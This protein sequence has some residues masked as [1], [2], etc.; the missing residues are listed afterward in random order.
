LP[1]QL[2]LSTPAHDKSLW[3]SQKNIVR[4]TFACDVEAP[5][6]GD[7]LIQEL[8]DGGDFHEEDLSGSFSF[9]LE[10][11]GAGD[12][13]LRIF[14]TTPRLTHRKWYT[15]RNTGS[16]SG[17]APFELHYVVQVGDATNDG[18]VLGVDF[19]LVNAA[20]PCLSGCGDA[21]R[22]DI[23]GD[24]F[25]VGADASLVNAHIASFFVPKPSEH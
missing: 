17:V 20:I 7:V 14:E 19:S 8:L 10:N 9:T 4:L 25:I 12:R 13:I 6:A 2:V 15:I 11:P 18:L 24:E 21:R 1:A 16:W 23:N 22:E 5:G 3:R